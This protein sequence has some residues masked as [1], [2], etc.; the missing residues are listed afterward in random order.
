MNINMYT[1][2]GEIPNI[3]DDKDNI[4]VMSCDIGKRNFAVSICEYNIKTLQSYRQYMKNNEMS[5]ITDKICTNNKI[6]MMDLVDFVGY[7]NS[8]MSQ[9]I[10]VNIVNY[11]DTIKPWLDLCSCFVLEKQ[12]KRNPEAMSIEQHIYSYLI[13]K[14]NL[15]KERVRFPSKLKYSEMEFPNNIKKKYYRKKWACERIKSILEKNKD[16]NAID[17]IFTKNKTKKDDLSDTLLQSYSFCKRI[18]VK[19]VI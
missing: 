17:Y 12:I 13:I 5:V 6:V 9:D 18:F 16:K 3:S 7:S 14:Y 2:I 8:I 4:W 1:S 19:E 15:E 11:L 10:Y